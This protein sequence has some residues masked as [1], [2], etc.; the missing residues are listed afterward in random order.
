LRSDFGINMLTECSRLINTFHLC[1][2]LFIE[3]RRNENFFGVRNLDIDF[4]SWVPIVKLLST[5]WSPFI[6][7]DEIIIEDFLSVDLNK[8]SISIISDT[9]TI[10]SLSD[11]I[12][13]GL[14]SNR[15]LLIVTFS[16]LAVFPFTHVDSKK[17]LAN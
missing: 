13:N 2:N 9:T 17:V 16:W 12:L 4:I 8:T 14:P 15:L 1:K 10:V 7:R 3:E 6:S 11:K 5:G